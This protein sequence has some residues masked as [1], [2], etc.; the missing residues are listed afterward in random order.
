MTRAT[1]A[2]PSPQEAGGIQAPPAVGA[3]LSKLRERRNWSLESLSQRAGVSKSMLSQIERGQANPTVAV[4]W[5]L[6]NALG[7]PLLELLEPGNVQNAQPKVVVVPAAQTPTLRTSDELGELQILGP[8][9]TAG[10]FEWYQLQMK[11]GGGL[12][13]QPHEPGTQEHFTVLSG[14]FE[15]SAGT[16]STKVTVGETARYP[17]DVAHSI[18]NIGRAAGS[19]LLVVMHPD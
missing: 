4:V 13:S 1:S 7:V 12:L 3:Q 5:R 17:A 19:G 6:A 15:V 16:V 8:I 18:R 9:E 11:A 10:H 14:S 2:T